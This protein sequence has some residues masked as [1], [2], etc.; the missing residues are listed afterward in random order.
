MTTRITVW[1]T[2]GRINADRQECQVYL[3]D[4]ATPPEGYEHGLERRAT[5]PS[6]PSRSASTCAARSTAPRSTHFVERVQARR[7]RGRERLRQRRGHRPGHRPD[8]DRRDEGPG[9]RRR[10]RGRRDGHRAT[11][12][13]TVAAGTPR[14]AR[15]RSEPASTEREAHDGPPAVRRQPVLRRQ[16]HVRGEGARAGDAL[17]GHR[18]RHRRAGRRLRRGR[19]HL[20]VHHARP[21]REVC[22]HV[23]ADPER[24]PDFT[25]YPVHALR[26]QVRQRGHRGRHARRGPAVPARRGAAQRGVPRRLSRWPRRTSRA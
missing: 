24:Y 13:A 26:P 8:D 25:F 22:D 17:P 16:P 4:T 23:R 9:D 15:A 12:P 21:H 3:R 7:D 2:E 6:S 5:R 14:G 18:R 10:A 1:G 19:P 20:H 11:G